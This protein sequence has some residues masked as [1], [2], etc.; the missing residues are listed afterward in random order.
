MEKS[1]DYMAR[2]F[3]TIKS[4]LKSLSKKYY[5]EISEGFED[6]SIGS[7]F[8]D[9]VS[10]VGDDLS[11]S[12]DR[13]YNENNAESMQ[14]R[15]S[16][17]NYA[18]MNNVKVP[19]AKCSMVE[20]E[21][22]CIIGVNQNKPNW[23]DCPI[24]KRDTRVSNGSFSFTLTE[25]VDFK[26]QFNQ[27]GYS[28]RKYQPNETPNGAITSYTVSKSVIAIA[29]ES[30][31]YKKTITE[32]ELQPFMEVV[33]PETNIT[34]VDSIIF[35]SAVN[36]SSNPKL[37]E[38]FIDDEEYQIKDEYVKTYRFFEVDSLS[39]LY[40]FGTETNTTEGVSANTDAYVDYTETW[41]GDSDDDSEDSHYASTRTTR[42]YKG[43]WKA[44]K[45]KFITEY[46]DKGYLKI[47]FG[48]G[49]Y[50]ELPN[51]SNYA[52]YRMSNLVNND[53]LGVLP[54]E[55]WTMYVMYH[56]GG[57]ADTNIAVNSITTIDYLDIDFPYTP[58]NKSMTMNSVKVTNLSNAVAGKDEPSNEE[59]KNLVKYKVGAQDRCV[60]V[61]DYKA[62]L[63]T[64]PPKYGCPY[65]Y[66][67]IE[68]N[69]KIVMPL[70]CLTPNDKLDTV[71][72]NILVDN[73]KEY[74]KE[75][76]TLTDYIEMK[77]GK[78]YNLGFEASVYIDKT[79]TT[80]YVIKTII[81]TI[82]SYMDVDKH[83]M[84]D[85]VFIGDLEKEINKI[86]GVIALID[87]KVYNI[88]GGT[89]G[90]DAKFPIIENATSLS[91]V[92]DT[93]A[94]SDLIDLEGMDSLL[95]NDYDS[96]FEIKNPTTDIAIKCKLK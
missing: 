46:T 75:Y 39:D 16:V 68:E 49:S 28:N 78:V 85:S 73:I 50:D 7:W 40:R 84:G 27:D 69:N 34:N 37:Y 83:V 1:I 30:K 54:Q 8:I 90:S 77:S 89:Y 67:A 24:I 5:P 79:Y 92:T 95:V 91:T 13:A 10:A 23:N 12:I 48:S 43:K 66:N 25:D 26:Q 58:D 33:L 94:I 20:V 82:K 81:D 74:L 3:N 47:T 14:S 19:G 52:E 21:F 76:K 2:D 87:L 44:V 4:E 51:A 53:M 15:K 56:V 35:K 38:Y 80:E 9:L 31:I 36:L 71:L 6:A 86:D 42:V 72:P 70:L 22:S 57:G 41:S 88:H 11:Y 55:G 32:S 93:N 61:N 29:G 17:L 63:A 64:M 62:K 45:Q 96:M 60:T 59:I 18:R 65:R